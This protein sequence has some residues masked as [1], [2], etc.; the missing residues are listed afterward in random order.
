[1]QGRYI[2]EKYKDI[3]KLYAAADRIRNADGVKEVVSLG[4]CTN[5]KQRYF[6]RGF[7]DRLLEN[8]LFSEIYFGPSQNIFEKVIFGTPDYGIVGHTPEQNHALIARCLYSER[9][10]LVARPRCHPKSQV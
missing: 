8:G 9:I 1:M 3:L 4:F 7:M 10:V 5:A 2:Y 6:H